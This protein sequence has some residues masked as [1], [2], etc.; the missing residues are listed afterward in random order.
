M[1]V[2][3]SYDGYFELFAYVSGFLYSFLNIDISNFKLIEP[4]GKFLEHFY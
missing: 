3:T 4:S 2:A 1:E